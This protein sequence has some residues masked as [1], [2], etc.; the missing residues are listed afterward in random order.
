MKTI[1]SPAHCSARYAL[2]V[3]QKPGRMDRTSACVRSDDQRGDVEIRCGG[4]SG[5]LADMNR[6]VGLAHGPC[7]GVGIDCDGGDAHRATGPQSR[8]AISPRLAISMDVRG[9]V[10]RRAAASGRLSSAPLVERRPGHASGT[11]AGFLDERH[12][13]LGRR[14]AG[15]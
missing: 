8:Q 13:P 4:A 6:S 10:G 7:V 15:T 11:V 12:D 5:A 2:R 1:P 3:S 9:A 14:L